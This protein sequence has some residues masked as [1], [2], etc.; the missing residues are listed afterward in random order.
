LNEEKT[1]ER[2][3]LGSVVVNSQKQ[4]RELKKLVMRKE[5]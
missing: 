2:L 5:E 4:V 1:K 3:H